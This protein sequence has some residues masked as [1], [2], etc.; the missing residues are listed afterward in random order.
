MGSDGVSQP[1][2]SKIGSQNSDSATAE[3]L[4]LVEPHHDIFQSGRAFAG[5][6]TI[7]ALGFL[8]LCLSLTAHHLFAAGFKAGDRIDHDLVATHSTLIVDEEATARERQ[9]I[10][11]SVVPV[12]KKNRKADEESLKSLRDKINGVAELQKAGLVPLSDQS[13]LTPVE[14]LFLLKLDDQTFNDLSDGRAMPRPFS[15]NLPAEQLRA[16][17]NKLPPKS[18]DKNTS[19]QTV[20]ST[21]TRERDTLKRVLPKG[22]ETN[23]S[24]KLLALSIRPEDFAN[25]SAT[26]QSAYARMCNNICRVPLDENKSAWKQTC[27]EYLPDLMPHDLRQLSATLM[28]ESA[29]PNMEIDRAATQTKM[30]RISQSVKPVMKH[31]TVGQLIVPKN[32][33]LTPESI[34]SLQGIGISDINH[35]PLVLSLWLSLAAAIALVGMY[36]YAYDPKHLFSAPSVGLIFTVSVMVCALATTVGHTY[37]MFVP[38]PAVALILT[39]FFGQ[40]VAIALT[41]LITIFL[42][43]DHLVDFNNLVALSAAAGSVI[44]TYSRRRHA[45]MTSGLCMAFAQ[46]AGYLLATLVSQ[47]GVAHPI[48]ALSKELSLE[49]AGGISSTIVAIGC[50]P[51]LENIFGMLTPFRLAELTD[52]DQPLLRRLEENAPGT[53]Q[54]SLAVANLAEAGARAIDGDVNLVR[55]GAMYHDIGKMVRP[56]FFIE[57]QLGDTNPHDAMTPEDSRERV[58]AHVTDGLALA[59]QYNLP[60]AVQDFIPMHQGTSLMAYFYHKACLRDGQE[61]VDPMFYRYPGP[62][63]QSKETSI[64]MLADVSEAVTHSMHD[65]T[66]EE[67]EVAMS[68]VFQNRWDDGQFSESGLTYAELERVKKAF[69]HVW[70]TLHHERLKYPSTTTG[71]MAV[72]PE[73]VPSTTAKEP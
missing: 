66:Q 1:S 57:N 29:K 9:K 38:L 46:A 23:D 54:H 53:Y 69:V 48:G 16:K 24:Q 32:S 4:S 55:A 58:L 40:R 5:W 31:I 15:S 12:F 42:A 39:I 30:E 25:Y 10:Q 59:K 49:F 45:L 50:L 33:I 22:I 62:K 61:N 47:P 52:A 13:G 34:E 43:A 14:H 36:L 2:D 11:D 6:L 63:A 67:V 60:R 51:F 56:R 37:P 7:C 71:K 35:W 65:P 21:L 72:P 73:A 18:S 27:T 3:P 19:R 70:R 28:S 68:K 64:V 8:A 44:G 26:V 17:L 41:I 20:L